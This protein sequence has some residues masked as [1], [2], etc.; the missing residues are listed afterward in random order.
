MQTTQVPA[1]DIRDSGKVHLGG[2]SPS[3]PPHTAQADVKDAGKVRSGGWSPSLP[4]AKSTP[5]A[6]KDTG[7]VCLG[8][9]GPTLPRK[10]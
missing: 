10:A 8:G 7:K 3:L 6:V 5:A 1:R 9:W 2:W 4:V